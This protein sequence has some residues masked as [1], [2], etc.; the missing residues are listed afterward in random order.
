VR[1]G[2]RRDAEAEECPVKSM[3][4]GQFNRALDQLGVTPGSQLAARILGFSIRHV[5]RLSSGQQ[6]ISEQTRL[7]L[8]MYQR[9]GIPRELKEG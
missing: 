5:L 4:P 9:N 1:R 6:R 7:L 3:T 2:D 8:D